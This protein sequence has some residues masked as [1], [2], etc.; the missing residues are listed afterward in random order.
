MDK[1]VTRI[2]EFIKE[3]N[4]LIEFEE[5]IQLL[6]TVDRQNGMK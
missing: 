2:Y 5:Q 4:N 1:I 3:T 6:A